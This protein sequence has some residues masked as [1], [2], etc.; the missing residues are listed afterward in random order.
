[1]RI[2]I[3]LYLIDRR[4]GWILREDKVDISRSSMR[5]GVTREHKDGTS[6][7]YNTTRWRVSSYR[8]RQRSWG[9]IG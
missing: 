8:S 2:P 4:V 5:Q 3:S 6:S 1:M 9:E 7:R